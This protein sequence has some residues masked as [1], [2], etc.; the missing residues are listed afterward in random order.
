MAANQNPRTPV[1]VRATYDAAPLTVDQ[2]RVLE[3]MP[4]P[5]LRPDGKAVIASRGRPA[6]GQDSDPLPPT[7]HK[8]D[9][10]YAPFN[11]AGRLQV[12]W[13]SQN[14]D[15]HCTGQIVGADN[16]LLTAA[17]CVRWAGQWNRNLRFYRAFHDGAFEDGAAYEADWIGITNG[18]FERATSDDIDPSAWEW[19]YA[20]L[21]MRRACAVGG[22]ELGQLGGRLHAWSSI[23][24][25]DNFRGGREMLVAEGERGKSTFPGTVK[26]GSNPMGFG[27][28]GGAWWAASGG[29]ASRMIGLNSFEL[30][31]EPDSEF[32]PVFNE[33]VQALVDH[34]AG[35]SS[36]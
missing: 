11:R 36:A 12:H 18:W 8:A 1:V 31:S 3:P 28:S 6:S 29:G 17:H 35:L 16:L 22:Q 2:L 20:V 30:D 27:S 33:T 21:R 13:S 25:P 10:H 19:D 15:V 14:K 7:L 9:L 24:Y 26:M 4:K 23:G 5:V 32:G 34:M